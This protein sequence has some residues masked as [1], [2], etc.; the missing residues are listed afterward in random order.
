MRNRSNT[1]GITTNL[2]PIRLSLNAALIS[3]L[4][5]VFFLL[6]IYVLV[7]YGMY[8]LAFSLAATAVGCICCGLT[9]GFLLAHRRDYALRRIGLLAFAVG[10]PLLAFSVYRMI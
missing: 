3:L 10:L 8:A 7:F 4:G 6:S 2:I 1:F 9:D 5:A